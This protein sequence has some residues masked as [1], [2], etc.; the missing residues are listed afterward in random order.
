MVCHKQASAVPFDFVNIDRYIY[1]IRTQTLLRASVCADLVNI[2]RQ[3]NGTRT[4][5]L[6]RASVCA[7][8]PHI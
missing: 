2:D 4:Q 7:D 3:R 8:W 6:L 5:T 1:G